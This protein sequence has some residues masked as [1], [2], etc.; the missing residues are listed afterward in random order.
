M[1][2]M[3]SRL[4]DATGAASKSNKEGVSVAVS[5]ISYDPSDKTSKFDDDFREEF[6]HEELFQLG[7]CDN[8]YEGR[9]LQMPLFESSLTLAGFDTDEVHWI[10]RTGSANCL[11]FCGRCWER[12]GP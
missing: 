8:C 2:L 4:G 9:T 10:Q 3:F 5:E 1:L 7:C 6:L 12:Q 11:S